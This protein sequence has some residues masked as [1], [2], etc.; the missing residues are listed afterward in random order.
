MDH[1]CLGRE[2]KAF[3]RQWPHF[4]LFFLGCFLF[5][6]VV[7]QKVYTLFCLVTA[8]VRQTSEEGLAAGATTAGAALLAPQDA[9][10][11]VSR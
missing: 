9:A 5:S 6:S 3:S 7:T 8:Q 4:T 10:E 2:S 11:S 1:P